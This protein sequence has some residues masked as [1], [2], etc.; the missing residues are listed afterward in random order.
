MLKAWEDSTIKQYNST[1]K[2]WWSFNNREKTDPYDASIPKILH[3]LTERY[4]NGANHGT[5]NSARSALAIIATENIEANELIRKF[6]KGNSKTR[7]AKPRYDATWDVN[8]V[9]QQLE[10]LFPLESLTL[11]QL[12]HKLILLLALG[13]AH[14][15]QTLTLI[16][17]ANISKSH[18]GLEIRIPERIKSTGSSS[19]R[20]TLKLP[21]FSEKPELCI[22]STLLY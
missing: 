1:L 3:F 20:T 17:I 12:S 11:K 14:R 16:R 9:L 4:Q 18:T 22:A 13:T 7:P 6:L 21:F 8:P 19:I 15:L 10:K 5:L 2:L